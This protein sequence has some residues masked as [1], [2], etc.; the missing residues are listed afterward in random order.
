MAQKPKR[1]WTAERLR[2]AERLWAAGATLDEM[3]AKLGYASKGSMAGTIFY[4]RQSNPR[5]FPKRYDGKPLN[6]RSQAIQ[7][8]SEAR[9]LT[10]RGIVC[11]LND[12]FDSAG[13]SLVDAVL[14]DGV[15]TPEVEA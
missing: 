14:D 3:A 2:E 9:G 15:Q 4:L 11:R 5:A 7:A 1:K 13:P 8:A 12:A 6:V 10:Y